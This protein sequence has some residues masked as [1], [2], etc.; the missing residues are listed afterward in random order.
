MTDIRLLKFAIGVDEPH[1]VAYL[2]I[3]LYS[4]YVEGG[5]K[6]SLITFSNFLPDIPLKSL[7]SMNVLNQKADF[8]GLADIIQEEIEQRRFEHEISRAESQAE[9][10]PQ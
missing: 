10:Y 2:M 3:S 9:E 6:S 4:E 1:T 8:G 7:F 5:I